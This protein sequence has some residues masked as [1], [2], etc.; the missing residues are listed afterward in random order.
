MRLSTN[1][2]SESIRVS[3][4]I[5]RKTIPWNEVVSCEAIMA[6]FGVYLG[7]GI[8][9]GADDSLAFTTSFGN[10]VR[11]MRTNGRAFVFSTRNPRELSRIINELSKSS[12]RWEDS[13]SFV[14]SAQTS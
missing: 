6:N 9:L 7:V 3:Y 5:I 11:I 14:A 2:N 4:G 1:V 13:A 10:A 8:R 12:S